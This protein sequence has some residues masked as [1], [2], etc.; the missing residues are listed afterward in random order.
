MMTDQQQ[1]RLQEVIDQGYSFEIGHHIGRGFDFFK[2]NM[3]SFIGY[4]VVAGLITIVASLIPFLGQLLVSLIL[5]PALLLGGYLAAHRSAE[6]ERLAFGDF[7]KGFDFISPLILATLASNLIMV[8]SLIPFFLVV[9]SGI[10]EFYSMASDPIGMEAELP[11]FPWWSFI[12]AL[13]AV[14]FSV[15][16]S[17][18]TMFIGFYGMSFWDALEMSR[19]IITKRWFLYFVFTVILGFM[20]AFSFLLLL[21]GA[22]FALPVLICAQYSVF[23]EVTQLNASQEQDITDHLVG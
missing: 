18:A 13:P 22:L 6:G 16:Y 11:D 1:R 4:I 3:G 10:F 21:V 19:K 14:Y 8:A 15:A 23:A 17:W 2:R 5:T 20:V 12:L 7:F 9:G